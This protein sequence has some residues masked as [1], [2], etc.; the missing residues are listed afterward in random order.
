[1]NLSLVHL[2][3]ERDKHYKRIEP[4]LREQKPD[5]VCMQEIFERD[6][7]FFREVLDA[8]C[9]FVPMALNKSIHGMS[10]EGI[11][12]FSRTGFTSTTFHQLGGRE[13]DLIPYVEGTPG[14]KN[15]TQRYVLALVEVP[16]EGKMYSIGTTHFPVT[17]KGE[18][19]EIQEGVLDA[20]LA[21]TDSIE[22]CL[23]TGD[24]NAPRGKEIFTKLSENFT[25]NVPEHYKSSLDDNLHRAG[26]IPFMVDGL[27]SRGNHRVQNVGMQCGV[28]DHCALTAVVEQE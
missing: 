12:V 22:S 5:V 14:E 8:E 17:Y 7:P 25:D 6:I 11:A 23:I 2:N 13:G 18:I 27:F 9:F 15:E 4:F 16:Y 20:F 28:S 1:M 26:P 19:N 10:P 21:A 24:F 3:I